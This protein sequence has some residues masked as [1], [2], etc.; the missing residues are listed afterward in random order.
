MKRIG[1]YTQA[2]DVLNIFDKKCLA[3]NGISH[4]YICILVFFYTS[5]INC[6]FSRKVWY[7]IIVRPCRFEAN[8]VKILPLE[9]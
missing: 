2:L 4:R 3:I 1:P 5:C 8:L 9:S 6:D 7:N